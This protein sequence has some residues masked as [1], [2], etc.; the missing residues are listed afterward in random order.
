MDGNTEYCTLHFGYCTGGSSGAN[1]RKKY[2]R[3]LTYLQHCQVNQLC[4][5]VQVFWIFWQTRSNKV[6]LKCP[7]IKIHTHRPC[8]SETWFTETYKRQKQEISN[9]T[10]ASNTKLL[11]HN[12]AGN[13]SIV[14]TLCI[15]NIC[16]NAGK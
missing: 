14:M 6:L 15:Y 9:H 10:C 16:A 1:I 11:K 8:R 5:T 3:Y 12:I 13:A 4:I 2:L 7:S